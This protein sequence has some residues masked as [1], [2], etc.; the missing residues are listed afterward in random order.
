MPKQKKVKGA[1][2]DET[3]KAVGLPATGPV[4]KMRGQDEPEVGKGFDD[5][6]TVSEDEDI[7]LNS[8]VVDESHL[9]TDEKVARLT[10]LYR[11]V[12]KM[13]L[14]IGL[15]VLLNVFRNKVEDVRSKDPKKQYSFSAIS[16]HY[17]LPT[18][19][20][21]DTLRRYVL[22]AATMRELQ[23][24]GV[25]VDSLDYSHFREIAKIPDEGLREKV[26]RIVVEQSATARQ[27]ERL[28]T[29][30]LEKAKLERKKPK[31]DGKS[32]PQISSLTVDII[33]KLNNPEKHIIPD[34]KITALL[35]D[36]VQARAKFNFREQTKIYEKAEKV[37]QQKAEEKS[38]LEKMSASTEANIN[39]LENLMD[40]FDGES[41]ITK[42]E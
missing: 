21:G 41:A 39:F 28:V 38:N 10:Q 16:T 12:A 7:D 31:G 17:D 36:P 24:K 13:Q 11:R 9:S 25:V 40:T 3:A 19:L 8:I 29:V 1:G 20:K 15:W 14:V 2:K 18:E 37:L 35:L 30:E 26:G 6:V 5:H 32:Q 23:G 42:T 27:T 4:F 33:G 34:D 22:A